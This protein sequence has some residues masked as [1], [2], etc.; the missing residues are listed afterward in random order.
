M[1]QDTFTEVTTQSWFGRLG[2]SCSSV[3]FGIVL[4]IAGVILLFWNEGRAVRMARALNEG[5]S[6]AIS[7][8]ADTID[9]ANEG[10]LIHLTADAKTDETLSDSMFGVSAKAIALARNVEMYQWKEEESSE[11]RKKLGGSTETVTTYTYSKAWSDSVIDSSGFKKP[12]NHQNPANKPVPD[13]STVASVVTVGAF[14]LSPSLIG[15]I[16][17]REDVSIDQS[18]LANVGEGM[19][20][21]IS[22][23]GGKFYFGDDP[24]NP[25]IGDAR[26]SF[27]VVRPCRVSLVAKQS[28][29]TFKP[30][31][32]KNGNKV[33][34][35]SVGD[36]SKDDMFAAAKQGNATLAWILRLVGLVLIAMGML[37]L[38]SPLQVLSDFIPFVG[39]IVGAGSCLSVALAAPCLALVVIAA[40]WFAYR[41]LVSIGLVAA[42]VVGVILLRKASIAK[43]A[44]KA[45]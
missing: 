9:P 25:Q 30:Y 24:G 36:Y 3:V 26:V 15:K 33:E 17:K 20:Q 12:G 5:Q 35:L 2:S 6:A 23:S 43:R 22:I 10:K 44:K 41:P 45:A 21:R 8:S 37:A 39:N 40:G 7:V 28:G 38:F 34:L 18:M 14:R 16:N 11:T 29:N 27:T 19:G 31:Q 13:S 4:L 42:A 1:S 32:A